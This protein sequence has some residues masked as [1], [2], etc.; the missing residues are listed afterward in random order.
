MLAPPLAQIMPSVPSI[1][2]QHEPEVGDKI[3]RDHS[4]GDDLA[5]EVHN[6][7]ETVKVTPLT[8]YCSFAQVAPLCRRPETEPVV[9]V[10]GTLDKG[11]YEW[12]KVS[13]YVVV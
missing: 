6:R 7:S 1:Q 9:S 2:V 8:V 3:L 5:V 13:R 12:N 10:M 11:L 4:H